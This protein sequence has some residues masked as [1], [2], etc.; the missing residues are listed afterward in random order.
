MTRLLLQKSLHES[1]VLLISCAILLFLFCWIR[2]WVVCQFDLQQLNSIIEQLRRFERFIPVPLEQLLTYS[3]SIAMVFH[4]PILILCVMVWVIAR[5]SDAVSGEINRGTMEM[6]LAQPVGRLRW[7]ACHT[8]VCIVGLI[9]LC[10]VCWLGL[11]YGIHTLSVQQQIA[12]TFDV[13]LP[14]LP[15]TLPVQIGPAQ[16]VETPLATYVNASQFIAPTCNL[17]AMSFFVLG[18]SLFCSSW[19]RYR[20]RTLGIV[21]GIF[22]VQFMLQ[23]LSKATDATAFVANFTFLTAY[24]PDAIVYFANDTPAAAWWLWVP[25]DERTRSWPHALGPLGMTLLLLAGGV[26]WMLLA[27]WRFRTR[28]IPAPL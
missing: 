16:Q 17:F 27:A 19:D 2:V 13:S 14:L 20:W 6:L 22:I 23:I 7:L 25:L 15:W 18:L 5:G 26:V 11:A 21:M 4:E 12:P 8:S 28:D 24:K 3:G 1:A 10:G 9:A